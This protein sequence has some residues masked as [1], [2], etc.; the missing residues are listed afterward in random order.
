MHTYVTSLLVAVTRILMD[1]FL[2]EGIRA[3]CRPE[4]ALLLN[5]IYPLAKIEGA[6]MKYMYVS[7]RYRLCHEVEVST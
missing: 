7:Y 5:G 1:E 4:T 2:L 6:Y 3:L